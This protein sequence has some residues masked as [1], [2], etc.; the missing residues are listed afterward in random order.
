M[1]N[2]ENLDKTVFAG[3]PP[4]G[5]PE[6]QSEHIDIRHLEWIPFNYTNLDT[7]ERNARKVFTDGG[8]MDTG[9]SVKSVETVR[10]E[11][12]YVFQN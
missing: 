12:T 7:I 6:I 11:I 5:I 9:I 4:Y 8:R 2:F 1:L 10:R 3:I